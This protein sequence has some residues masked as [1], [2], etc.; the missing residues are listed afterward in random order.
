MDRPA[1]TSPYPATATRKPGDVDRDGRRPG[2][3]APAI[4]APAPQSCRGD[5]RT[6]RNEPPRGTSWPLRLV[7]SRRRS[8]YQQEIHNPSIMVNCGNA[9]SG[10][11]ARASHRECPG[12]RT[13][14]RLI[15]GAPAGCRIPSRNM[16]TAAAATCGRTCRAVNHQPF[17]AVGHGRPSSPPASR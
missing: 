15:S 16:V 1:L 10:A 8:S 9:R 3:P 14:R 2:G 5:R 12:H 7:G 11:T 6:G 17:Q 4:P 13:C